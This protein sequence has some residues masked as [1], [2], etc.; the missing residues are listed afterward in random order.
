[1]VTFEKR[2]IFAGKELEDD[3]TISDYNIHKGNEL[4]M[5]HGLGGGGKKARGAGG[6]A[7][8]KD[9]MTEELK[10]EIQAKIIN[11]RAINDPVVN[12]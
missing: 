8:D 2:L 9:E 10:N 11:A 5:G 7:I 1:M 6:K 4:S 3:R 12:A